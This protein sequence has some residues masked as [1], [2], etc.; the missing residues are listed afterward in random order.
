M[1][2]I[3]SSLLAVVVLLG[4]ICFSTLAQQPA[5]APE[6]T[7]EVTTGAITGRVV[8]ER[9]EPMPGASV[10]VRAVGFMGASRTTSA[11]T[12]GNFRLNGL[13]AQLYTVSAYSPAYVFQLQ[14]S[15]SPTNYYRIG[16]SIK[17]ELIRGG[18]LTGT[19]TN[20]AGE[21]LVGIRVRALRI[22]EGSGPG[23]P[24][25]VVSNGFG[26]RPTDDRGMYRIYG[27]TAGTYI[28]SAGG[29]GTQQSIQLNPFEADVPTYSTSST[30][31]NAAEY[32]VRS[33][34]ETIADIRYRN[35]PGRTISGNVRVNGQ[36]GAAVMLF[37][38]DSI[39]VPASSA[40]QMPGTRGFAL[41]G[42]G[43]GEYT[44]YAQEMPASSNSSGVLP[45]ISV[46][47]VKRIV[48]KGADVTGIE[49]TPR[50]LGVVNGVVALEP[51]KAPECQNKRKPLFTEMLIELQR[52]PKDVDLAAALLRL[53][54]T[55]LRV[56][57]KGAFQMRNVLPARYRF[58]PRFYA[59]YW[60][61]QSITTGSAAPAAKAV[62]RN[63]AA[64]N[65]T[66]VRAGEQLSN[67]TI[68]LAEG[69]ASIR[70][71][72]PVGEG[73]TVPSSAVVYLVP[74][75]REKADDVLRYFVTEV[76]SDGA[77]M[78]NS[79]PP[80]R[81]WSLL[82]TPAPAEIATLT[83]LRLPESAEAR[84][85]LRR[86][87]ETQRSDVELKPCQTLNDYQLPSK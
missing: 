18:V 59:R 77:F 74:A 14:D 42:I 55:P 86:T 64:A 9:G 35:D 32:N 23:R 17:I 31:D 81:Y 15:E 37:S 85:K 48:V 58:N 67:I 1:C 47:E 44:V 8:N 27:L 13:E 5:R 84:T 25:R 69:A 39:D 34:E 53:N 46:S 87:A 11:D 75:E 12:E 41:T 63:D 7:S 76:A 51:S 78:L 20:A 49:L 43:D 61:L 52:N 68:T 38:T 54:A 10:F 16:D 3:S 29:A 80:G 57:A 56:D 40:Y 36:N 30:R 66:G 6:T 45:D 79:L 72:I 26:D 65:W 50:P 33:G 71:K 70:G 2:K 60:Y 73:A 28:V 22:A 4:S 83:K 19:V 62:A 24:T 21:P 82:Q